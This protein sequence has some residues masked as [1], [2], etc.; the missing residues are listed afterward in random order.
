MTAFTRSS[1]VGDASPHIPVDWQP[2][3]EDERFAAD[4][5]FTPAEIADMTLKFSNHYSGTGV[6][7]VCWSK[8]WRNW[9]LNER[10]PPGQLRVIQG[11]KDAITRRKYAAI[12]GNIPDQRLNQCTG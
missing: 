7:R 3:A 1:S 9:V 12:I 11:D 2:S 8:A 6:R 5:G 4:R 10:R